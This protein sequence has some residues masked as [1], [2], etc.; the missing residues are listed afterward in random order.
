[1]R[2]KKEL[3]AVIGIAVAVRCWLVFTAAGINGD[4]FWFALTTRQMAEQGLLAGMRGDF[5]WPYYP[6]NVALP[7]YPL[8]GSLLF[9]VLDDPVLSLRIVSALAGVALVPAV[10]ALCAELF[11]DEDLGLVAAVLVAFMPE[12][13]RAS[14][15]VYREV[16]MALW[17]VLGLLF[18]VWARRQGAR[19]V[20]WAVAAG[21]MSFVAF[22]TRVEGV[23]VL[24]A[25]GVIVLLLS[26]SLHWK[27]RA[28]FCI[29][30][31][32]AFL[33]LEMPYVVWME[34]VTGRWLFSQWQV[35]EE[36]V[37]L[38]CATD[39]FAREM[40]VHGPAE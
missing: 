15:A 28:A 3:L 29:V 23:V 30:M 21:V 27:K 18:V 9:R 2:G 20:G 40:T 24:G 10:Y 32:G 16:L 5:L 19:W 37:S 6:L 22:M 33:A 38:E 1:M 35:K 11:D 13:A 31:A 14:A 25:Y 39:H 7:V 17:L 36:F 12:F 8:L 34:R 26:P 4:A